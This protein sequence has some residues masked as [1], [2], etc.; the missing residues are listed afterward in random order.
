MVLDSP[1]DEVELPGEMGHFGVLPGHAPLIALLEIGEARYRVGK[2]DSYVAIGGG[3]AEVAGDKVTVLC[4]FA[5]LP[6]EIDVAAAQ[7][8]KAQADEEM[9]TVGPDTFDG[10]HAKL[11]TAE[12]QVQVAQRR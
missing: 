10:V 1:C 2:N 5:Q 7:R 12:T 3:F 6:G 8:A 11:E 9:K 4:D